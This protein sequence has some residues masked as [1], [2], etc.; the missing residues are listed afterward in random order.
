MFGVFPL[1]WEIA[2]KD[3]ETVISTYIDYTLVMEQMPFL[4]K[5]I[6]TGFAIDVTPKR[7]GRY[8]IPITVCGKGIYAIQ[9]FPTV[10]VIKK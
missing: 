5:N 9:E 3:P 8:L 7:V 10:E 6:E 1:V 2:K 4:P